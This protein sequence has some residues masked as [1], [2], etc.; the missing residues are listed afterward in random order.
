M[1][2]PDEKEVAVTFS[3]EC[4]EEFPSLHYLAPGNP[5]LQHLIETW[6]RNSDDS[7]RLFRYAEPDS[8]S[9]HPIVCGWGRDGTISVV[10]DDGAV[11]GATSVSNLS[12]WYNNFIANREQ[13]SAD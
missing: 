13:Y 6:R 2:A 7:E 4:A 9:S 8:Q 1:I 10:S 5:L 12:D 3:G 11:T